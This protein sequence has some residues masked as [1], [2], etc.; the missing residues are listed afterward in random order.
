MG[1]INADHLRA[2]SRH[3]KSRAAD[4]AT[5]IQSA[6]DFARGKPGNRAL[7]KTK[8]ITHSGRRVRH[9]GQDF[10]RRADERFRQSEEKGEEK[11][12]ALPLPPGFQ[13]QLTGQ[14]QQQR[15]NIMAIQT[16]Q[17]QDRKSVV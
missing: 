1:K 14:I 12:K 5:E 16:A 17:A 6:C 11:L 9:A 7:R 13:F 2:G 8:R 10:L 4:R 15:D 3:F